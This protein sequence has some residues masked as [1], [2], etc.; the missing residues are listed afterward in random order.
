MSDKETFPEYPTYEILLPS[1]FDITKFI[2]TSEQGVGKLWLILLDG[3]S[4]VYRFKGV[5]MHGDF[6]YIRVF[7]DI[8]YP[9]ESWKASGEPNRIMFVTTPLYQGVRPRE[10]ADIIFKEVGG[11]MMFHNGEEIKTRSLSPEG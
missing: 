6:G 11:K 10:V 7:I 1:H 9:R 8:I 4:G 2:S 5:L 3:D